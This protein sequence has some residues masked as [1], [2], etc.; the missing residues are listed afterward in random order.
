MEEVVKRRILES[1]RER[2]LCVGKLAKGE[3]PKEVQELLSE[4]LLPSDWRPCLAVGL[5]EADG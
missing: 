1:F 4:G 3:L 5:P 2:F